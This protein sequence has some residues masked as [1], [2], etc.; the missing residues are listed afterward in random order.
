M[1]HSSTT[2]LLV[3]AAIAGCARFQPVT[4]GTDYTPTGEIQSV[5]L[6]NT[7]VH[8]DP[9][10]LAVGVP[11]TDVVAKL[12]DPNGTETANDGAVEDVYAFYPDGSKF[13]NPTIR[14]RNIALGV[15]TGGASLAVRQLRL[16]HT[17]KKLTLYHVRYGDDGRIASVRVE[18]PKDSSAETPATTPQPAVAA[19]PPPASGLE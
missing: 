10:V 11:R 2:T 17:E 12:G 5:T 19:S 13:V 3:L 14:P 15:F 16:M 18:A 4:P 6:K 8:Y 1:K 7:S 9:A